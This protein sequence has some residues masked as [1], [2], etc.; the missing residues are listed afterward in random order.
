[1]GLELLFQVEFRPTFFGLFFSFKGRGEA[2][3]ILYA[4]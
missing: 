1:M 2:K 3:R 4:V